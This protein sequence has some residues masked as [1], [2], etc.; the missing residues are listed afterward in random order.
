MR[1]LVLEEPRRLS[2]QEAPD[3]QRRHERE[4][5]VRPLAV[6]T[7]DL[8]WLMISGQTPFQLPVHL[9]HECVAEI[10][11]GP[12]G[13]AAG[14]RVVI[15]FQISCGVCGRC[16]AEMTGN[17]SAVPPLSMYGFGT[18]G[19]AW[20]GM[21]SDLALVPYAETMLVALPEC[22]DPAV[23]ASAADNMTDGWRTVAP[24]LSDL[25]RAEVLVVGGGGAR[26][27]PLYA[28]DAAIA[29]GAASVT[30]VDTD[31]DRLAVAQLLGAKVVDGAPDRSLGAFPVTVDGT[32]TPDGLVATLRLTDWGGRCT[33]IGQLVPEAPLPL[34][35]LY[36]RGV[37]LHIGRAMARPVMPTILGLVAEGRLRP[38]LV[39]SE[40][41]PWEDAPAALL[42]PTTKLV[43][44]RT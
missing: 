32:G 9:G 33:S 34:F 6:A 25:P 14:E 8:D 12:D 1:S 35:E 29:L 37:N 2:W 4:A 44:S 20:G 31:P 40:T 18:L 38:H 13:F 21:L 16:Q 23:V 41:V 24:A 17:C 39:T 22:L 30:Y 36:T 5:I 19:G 15:P 26:S 28:V 43:M 11:E 7:C 10:V 42:Q 3:P 27:I